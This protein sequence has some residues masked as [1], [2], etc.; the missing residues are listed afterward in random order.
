LHAG[1]FFIFVHVDL[2]VYLPR[3][4]QGNMSPRQSD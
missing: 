3:H 1:N 4:V 2:D